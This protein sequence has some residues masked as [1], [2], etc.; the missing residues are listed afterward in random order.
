MNLSEPQGRANF[1]FVLRWAKK[2]ASFIR[3]KHRD[4]IHILCLWSFLQGLTE[5][6]KKCGQEIAQKQNYNLQVKGHYYVK[7]N[8]TEH[9]DNKH[10]SLMKRHTIWLSSSDWV[11]GLWK[12]AWTDL[13]CIAKE[14]VVLKLWKKMCTISKQCLLVCQF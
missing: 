13:R 3:P 2:N 14:L 11:T 12:I 4:I 5:F 1:H 7:I 6:L 8:W 9:L 10:I